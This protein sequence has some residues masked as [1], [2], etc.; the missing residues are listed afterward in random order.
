MEN[1]DLRNF[2]IENKLTSNS[3]L[4]SEQVDEKL[5]IRKGVR[6]IAAGA[7]MLAGT[8]G[9]QSQE[10]P[11]VSWQ[12]MTQA[13]KAAKKAEL[14]SKGGIDRFI[15][16]KDSISS[17]ATNRRDADFAKGAARKGM[18]VDQYRSYLKQNNKKA[19]VGLDGLEVGR[20]N[21]RGEKKGSCT[22]GQTM[23]GE[24]LKDVN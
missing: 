19:D 17:D 1:F 8:L 10:A 2:L 20:A 14:V 7:A 18:T 16:Y 15:Q 24:S 5:D 23:G 11:K 12:Q 3:K 6:N 9:A 13:E 22:T 21:K 4:L